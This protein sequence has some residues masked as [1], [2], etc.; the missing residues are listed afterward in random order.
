MGQ[1]YKTSEKIFKQV[2]DTGTFPPERK[3]VRLLLFMKNMT[4]KILRTTFQ[5][6]N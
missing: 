3:K 2:L 4:N 5:C 1:G 6:L